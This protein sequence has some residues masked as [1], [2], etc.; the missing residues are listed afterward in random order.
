MQDFD[1]QP[2]VEKIHTLFCTL[3][4]AYAYVYIYIYIYLCVT[5]K[6]VSM[7]KTTIVEPWE[8]VLIKVHF[9]LVILVM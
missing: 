6:H 2:Y 8:L 7:V 9:V 4:H 5:P 3:I 1:H